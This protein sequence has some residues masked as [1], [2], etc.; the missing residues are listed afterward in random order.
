MIGLFIDGWYLR[1][2]WRATSAAMLCYRHLIPTIERRCSEPVCVAYYYDALL[3]GGRDRRPE[4]M[5]WR[6][7]GFRVKPDYPS[8]S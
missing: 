2:A 4:M 6:H 3:H 1:K 8:P 7:A 5:A